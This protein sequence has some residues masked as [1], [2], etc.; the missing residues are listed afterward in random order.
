MDPAVKTALATIQNEEPLY[1]TSFDDWDS[2]DTGRNAALVNGKLI[3][4]SEDENGATLALNEYPSDRYAV[5]FE[6]SIL[7]DA[8]LR[9]SLRL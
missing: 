6:L 5:E 9:W 1:Q 2:D 8:I 3:L 4:T 7:E